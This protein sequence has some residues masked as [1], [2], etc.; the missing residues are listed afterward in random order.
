M[1]TEPQ[2]SKPPLRATVVATYILAYREDT[3]ALEHALLAEGLSPQT[4]RPTY[5]AEELAYSRTIRCL[6]NHLAAWRLAA[7]NSG[8]VLIVEADF[9]PCAGFGEFPL[10]FSPA[11]HGSKAWAFLYAGGPRIFRQHSDG[12]LQGHAACPVAYVIN[13][14]VAKALIEFAEGEFKRKPDLSQYS[15][16]DTQFQWHLMGKGILCFL[17]RRQY[18]EHGGISNPEHADEKTGISQRFSLLRILGVGKNH[19]ADILNGRLS[20]F[21]VY[22]YQS[23]WRYLLIRF[24]G[25]L[26]GLL[27]AVTGRAMAPIFDYSIK[28]KVSLYALSLCRALGFLTP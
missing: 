23:R 1:R 21:P 26:F 14:T 20:F 5:S 13:P 16:W 19:R 11:F 3:S 7:T 24:E 25:R 15:L 18:G 28:A 8:H 2:H 10:P 4:L 27:R 6:L 12:A 9:V 22:A 17:P